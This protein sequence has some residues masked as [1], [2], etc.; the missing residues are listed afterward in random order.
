MSDRGCDLMYAGRMQ[1]CAVINDTYEPRG[2]GTTYPVVR[3]IF[4]GRTCKEATGYAKAHSKT[5]V[6]YRDCNEDGQ[7]KSIV[8]PSFF[9]LDPH[10]DDRWLEMPAQAQLDGALGALPQ[11]SNKVG[12]PLV[13]GAVLAVAGFVAYGIVRDQQR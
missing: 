2:A 4:Y 9:E 6:F 13:I 7:Y 3:H 5:D 12:I 11:L 1:V 8:C 10:A